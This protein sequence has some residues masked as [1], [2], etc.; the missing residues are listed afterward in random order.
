MYNVHGKN[1]KAIP[2]QIITKWIMRNN[3]V[4]DD[5]WEPQDRN[6]NYID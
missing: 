6:N 5:R 2:Q 3:N 4:S 1:D